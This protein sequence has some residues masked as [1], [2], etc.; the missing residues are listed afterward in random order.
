MEKLKVFAG[1]RVL[2]ELANKTLIGTAQKIFGADRI[3]ASPLRIAADCPRVLHSPMDQFFF[4]IALDLEG[5]VRRNH[6]GRNQHN[7]QQQQQSEQNVAAIL[8][9]FAA[10]DMQSVS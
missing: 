10:G 5:E 8:P 4:P 1:H 7:A 9:S 2:V 3:A 6:G